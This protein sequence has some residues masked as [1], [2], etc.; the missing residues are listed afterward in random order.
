MWR[1]RWKQLKTAALIGNRNSEPFDYS[2]HEA[3][4]QRPSVEMPNIMHPA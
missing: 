1:A 3:D 4:E 2:M